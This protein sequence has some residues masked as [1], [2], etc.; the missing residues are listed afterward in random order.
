MIYPFKSPNFL[1]VLYP[2]MIWKMPSG[3]KKIYL[4]F[5]DGPIPDITPFVMDELN[6]FNAKATF[7][8]I[9][10]NIRKHPEVF[11]SLKKEGHTVANHTFNH[12]NGRKYNLNTYLENTEKCQEYLSDSSSNYF[13]PP[14]GRMKRSQINA[15]AEK[16]KIIMWDVLSGDFQKDLDPDKCLRKCIK[17]TQDGSI[18]LFHD[19]IKAAPVMKKVLPSFLKHF[20]NLGFEFAC[21]SQ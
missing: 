11:E 2:K 6:K 18:V 4:T 17:Y 7:F 16:Y 14:Y 9:G 3:E 19:S 21:L 8:C 10:D 13:R 12:L 20:S 1:Q 15:I 5:D